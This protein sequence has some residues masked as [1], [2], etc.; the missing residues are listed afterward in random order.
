VKSLR[1][2]QDGVTHFGAKESFEDNLN[3]TDANDYKFDA[4]DGMFGERHFSISYVKGKQSLMFH[5]SNF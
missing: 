5:H 4:A 3:S 1:N 2:R